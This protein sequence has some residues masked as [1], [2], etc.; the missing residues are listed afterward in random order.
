MLYKS[1]DSLLTQFPELQIVINPYIRFYL[2]RRYP[3]EVVPDIDRSDTMKEIY[4]FLKWYDEMMTMT[5]LNQTRSLLQHTTCYVIY[6]RH[7]IT[8]SM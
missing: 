8:I 5:I 3:K 6:L 4:K 1:E 2:Y 7:S